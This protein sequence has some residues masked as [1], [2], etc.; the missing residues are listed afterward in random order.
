M[1]LISGDVQVSYGELNARANQLAHYLR[2]LGVGPDTLVGVMVERSV[3][4]IVGLLAILKAGGAYVPLDPLYPKARLSFMLADAKVKILLTQETLL[5]QISPDSRVQVV[6]LDSESEALS[7]QSSQNLDRQSQPENLAYVIYT[8][9]S[10]GQPKGVLVSHEN[11][12]R[13]LE[14]TQVHFEFNER[15]VW[16]L[17][18]SYAF[19]FSVWEL[20]G[21]LAYGGRLVIVPYWISRSAEAF[22]GLLVS[23]QVTVLNQT[24]SAFRQLIAAD[25]AAGD[26]E[27]KLRLVIFG[28]EALELQSLRPWFARHGD[29]TPRL[30]NMFG[31]TETTVHVTYRALTAEDLELGASSVIGR[32]LECL[33]VYLLDQHGQPVPIGVPGEICVGG[34]GLARGYLN[35]A[36]LTSERFVPHPFAATPGARL[37]R[38]GDVGRFLRDGDIEYLGR[39]DQQVKVRGFRIELGEIEAVLASHPAVREAAVIVHEDQSGDKRL[40]AY[41]AGVEATGLREYLRERL[42]E[43]MVPNVFVPLDELPLTRNGKVDR[44][45][46]PDPAQT[47]LEERVYVTPRTPLEEVLCGIWADVL[48]LDQ[49]GID[50]NFFELGGHSLLATQLISRVRTSFQVE[51]PLRALFQQPTVA[52]LALSIEAAQM[53]E[54]K[55]APP[56]VRVS[57]EEP[58]P[59]SFAQQRLWFL[60]QLDPESGAYNIPAGVRL[61]GSLDVEAL[62]RSLA[63][64][65]RRH[66]SLRTSFPVEGGHVVQ[67]IGPPVQVRLEASDI[68]WL[69]EAK[70]E[71]E[72]N[73]AMEEEAG[74]PFDLGRGPLWRA[75]LLRLGEQEHIL[76]Y[77]MHHTIS[78]EWSMGVL[79]QE[80]ATLYKAFASGEQSPLE[81]LPVQYADYAVWQ[82]DLLQGEVLD[83]QLS[84]WQEQLKGAP[85]VLDL[86]TDKPRSSL[87]T[88]KG[89][90]VKV[91]LPAE[92]TQQ[93]RQLSRQESATLF[94]TLLAAFEVLLHRYTGQQDIVVG[95]PIAGRGRREVEGLVGAFINAL[96]IRVDLSGDP[97]FQELIRR[98]RSA[99][100][101]AFAHDE[102]PFEKLLEVLQPA[103]QPGY[104]PL[105]QVVFNY[106]QAHDPVIE[107]PN[108]S[109]S[110]LG[111]NLEK[112]KYD[113]TFYISEG[114]NGLSGNITYKTNLFEATTIERML[115]DFEKILIQVAGQPEARLS[116][117]VAHLNA[118][119]KSREPASVRRKAI[120]LTPAS[121]VRTSYLRP[122]AA[123]PLVVQPSIEELDLARWAEA[124]GD[125]VEEE[126]LKH[127]ALLFRGFDVSSVEDFRR[128]AGTVT[129]DLV[130]Y[131]EGSS[132]RILLGDQVY[133]SS[134]YPAEYFISL[135]NELSY[136]HKWPGRIFF[137][138]LQPPQQGGETPIADSRK[139]LNLISPQIKENF[140]RKGV[141]YVRNLRAGNGAGLSWQMV[142]ETDDQGFV[143]GYCREGGIEFE[144]KQEG[145]LRTSQ[146]RPAVARHP[147]TGEMVW[148]NQADQWHPSN[149]GGKLATGLGAAMKEEDLPINAYYGDGSPFDV[150]TL[151]AIRRAY[152]EAAVTFAWQ[153]GDVMLL[154]NMLVA[155]GR[156]PFS[157]PRR[158]AVAMGAPVALKEIERVVGSQL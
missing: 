149:L 89:A 93:L 130:N 80:V 85:P 139:V 133:T 41:V 70:H 129:T 7:R 75:R 107:L 112:A 38:S 127:G 24:P 2:E 60:Q 23:E 6:I 69:P 63:E 137:C 4:M 153:K 36:A 33:Q 98:V 29:R 114:R 117:I 106:L 15:D 84:Y 104:A 72:V 158:V 68:T 82:R 143:E 94:M 109:I 3:D 52:G 43:Y 110:F 32:P 113:L 102:M 56:V 78:D 126:L 1:A 21:A 79:I 25:E 46:L 81:E 77:T 64:V 86:P 116:T 144:W 148:F 26:V 48:K 125:F 99:V 115:T 134:E 118:G 67:R 14:A 16:T 111:V 51:L 66:E 95:T 92:L 8:S 20:W 59:L 50:D 42:P 53:A 146:V 73:R 123:F 87:Q 131:I 57:R 138:C 31:I 124:N 61:T 140:L 108:L 74:R 65:V 151:D 120:R 103:R 152:Q 71:S 28:G 132:E 39:I 9:G 88:T 19:D 49:V 62:E 10:T 55:L 135:H 136:A 97:T 76:L 54:Q 141:K 101:G 11:V 121:L 128:F 91:Q 157:G 35:R 13:L 22:H 145:G 44:R 96:A 34:T 17:F 156:M 58:L 100:L 83:E 119:L 18:H 150:P 154:D 37:Y 30:V 90:H 40:V 122:E 142:F 147:R 5:N 27:L 45:A 47:R 155:H 12:V 105:F